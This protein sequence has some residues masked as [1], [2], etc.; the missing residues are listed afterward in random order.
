MKLRKEL[1]KFAELQEGVLRAHDKTKGNK[2]WKDIYYT[3]LF[4]LLKDEVQ[5][6]EE[7]LTNGDRINVC[8]ECVDVAN[9]AMMISDNN[10]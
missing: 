2:G 9:F 4:R 5:E 10:S 6:L 1:Q 7:A 8:H 3:E